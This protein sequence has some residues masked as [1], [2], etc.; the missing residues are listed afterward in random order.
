MPRILDDS[1]PIGTVKDFAGGTLPVGWFACLGAAISRTTYA[2]LFAVIGTTYGAGDGSTTFNL[3]DAGGRVI[4]CKELV[5]TRL[6]SGGSGI[7]STTL[8]SAGGNETHT[9]TTAQMPSH[10]HGANTG[11]ESADHNHLGGWAGVNAN[12]TYGVASTT[13]AGNINTQ[14]GT[15]TTNHA[16]TSGSLFLGGAAHHVHTITAEGGG[17]AHQNTQP[18]LIMNKMIKY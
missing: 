2:G 16:Y 4:A 18:T 8:G 15:A 7:T 13:T 6:T 10:Q 11:Q 5:A 12:A 9:I 1:A 17:G 3:P 14:S